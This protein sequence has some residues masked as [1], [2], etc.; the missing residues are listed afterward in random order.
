MNAELL[1]EADRIV[2]ALPPGRR[3]S[4]REIV[5]D[6]TRRGYLPDSGRSFLDRV[7][8][9]GLLSDVLAAGIAELREGNG[10]DGI[11]GRPPRSLP[12]EDAGD[13]N[14]LP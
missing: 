12:R 11:H 8:G 3:E 10:A 1:A 5:V 14:H 6:A 4:V 13:Q 2:A 7:T 9:S